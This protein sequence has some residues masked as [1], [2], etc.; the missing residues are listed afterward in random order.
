[1]KKIVF[2]QR[3]VG[4]GAIGLDSVVLFPRNIAGRKQ[5][6]IGNRSALLPHSRIQAICSY[7]GR[8]YNPIIEVADDVYIGR[9]LYLTAA[10]GVRIGNGC[11]LSDHVYITDLNHGYDPLGGP[12]MSQ[13][14]KG[15]GPVVIGNNCFLG[16]R[17]A[18][19]PGRQILQ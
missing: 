13:P 19:M 17:V 4:L 8:K 15:K 7:G 6:R 9:H 16:F 12:I 1:M 3:P 5:I 11:V 10:Y 18:I 2:L 14:L